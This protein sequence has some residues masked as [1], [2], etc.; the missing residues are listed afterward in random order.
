MRSVTVMALAALCGGVAAGAYTYASDDG[1]GP[2]IAQPA[3]EA[4]APEVRAAAFTNADTGQCVNWTRTPSGQNTDFLTVDCKK[5]HRFEVSAREDLQAYPSSEFGSQG[6]LPDT[7]RQSELS[8]ELCVGPT[9]RYL[10]GKLDPN[11]RYVI[12]PILPPQ[13]SWEEG[14]RTMLCGVMV[15]DAEGRSLETTGLAADQDQSRVYDADTCVQVEGKS[16]RVV[17]C[18][19]DHTWQVTRQVDLGKIF[20][21]PAWPDIKRQNDA[22]NKICTEAAENYMGS[23]ENLDQS[24]LTPFWTTQPEESW[25]TGSRQANCSLI[26]AECEGFATLKGG[27]REKFTING[28][29]PKTPP[30]RLPKRSEAAAPKP[31]GEGAEAG[32]PAG[33]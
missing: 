16:T 8:Q 4:N 17:P 12:T 20:D 18:A 15:Q 6:K 11:G 21:D 3:N 30:K 5:P 10:Q 32:A 26:A 33:N 7:D 22:L 14:D 27:V 31:E 28:K 25:V 2:T 24:T 23:E 29:P 19:E 1:T 13:S 9:M